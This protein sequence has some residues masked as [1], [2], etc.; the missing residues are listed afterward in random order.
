M[1]IACSFIHKVLIARG[2]NVLT[3]II[4]QYLGISNVV[5]HYYPFQ[6]HILSYY[7]IMILSLFTDYFSSRIPSFIH[8]VILYA[9]TILANEQWKRLPMSSS[10]DGN[11]QRHISTV[12]EIF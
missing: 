2:C 1:C 9:N 11:S 4:F 3:R 7:S 5:I 12:S 8:V 10:T 6:R